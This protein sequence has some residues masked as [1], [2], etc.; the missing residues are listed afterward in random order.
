[1]SDLIP[2][3]N[4]PGYSSCLFLHRLRSGRVLT[5]VYSIDIILYDDRNQD[6]DGDGI[7][8]SSWGERIEKST[9]KSGK[10]FIVPGGP[11]QECGREKS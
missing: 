5:S 6:T 4:L 7:C 3:I 8:D 2:V 11:Q 10:E 9:E 1:M